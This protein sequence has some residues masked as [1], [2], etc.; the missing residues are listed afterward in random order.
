MRQLEA[1]EG[2]KCV[3]Y[4]QQ[5]QK[6]KSEAVALQHENAK[7]RREVDALRAELARSHAPGAAAA[8]TTATRTSR[9]RA[10]PV[11]VE[12]GGASP[13]VGIPA[14]R[15][16][17]RAPSTASRGRSLGSESGSASPAAVAGSAAPLAPSPLSEDPHPSA[18]TSPPGG[19]GGGPPGA[20]PVQ[21]QIQRCRFCS[22]GPDCFCAQVGFDIAP[23][24]AA[25]A[26]DPADGQATGS[27]AARGLFDDSVQAAARA[28]DEDPYAAETTY[29][30]AVPLRLR[31]RAPGTPKPKSVWALDE[32]AAAAVTGAARL[33][34]AAK[35]VC[36]GDP[37]N[38]PACSD[39]P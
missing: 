1:G 15:R 9:T 16:R 11:E 6:A 4:Q 37:S 21:I 35:A 23:T 25:S 28:T 18:P 10:A 30:P 29:E 14:K 22:T 31:R 39:D 26:V 34:D 33:I 7:L 20:T 5:A 17:V 38:C 19:G 13:E 32:P 12:E 3:F 24:P 36:S 8:T 27:K 2:E